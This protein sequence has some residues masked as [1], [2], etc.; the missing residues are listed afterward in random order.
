MKKRFAALVLGLALL[1]NLGCPAWA[2]EE[3]EKENAAALLYSMELFQGIGTDAFGNPIFALDKA[4]TRA[5]SVT[6]LVR[7]LGGEGEVLAGDWTMPF[8][9]VP[10]WAAGYVAYAY[11]KG[12]TQG[13][14]PT[15]FDP[16][17]P[18][19]AAEYLSFVLRALGYSSEKDFQW[20]SAWTLTDKLGLTKKEYDETTSD[21][22]RGDMAW[23]SFRALEQKPKGQSKALWQVLE[24]EDVSQVCWWQ[25]NVETCQPGRFVLSFAPV[26]FL[27]KK[28]AY[29]KF[30]VTKASINGVACR[31][32][33]QYS[34]AKAVKDHI[35][36]REEALGSLDLGEAFALVYLKYDEAAAKA[37]ASR[38]E[39]LN[40]VAY[41][42]LTFCLELT[43]TRKDGTQVEE[44]VYFDYYLNGYGGRL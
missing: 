13:R 28:T 25:E 30:E 27:G 14:S 32:E 22:T 15:R 24:L 9:D 21:F 6:M 34:T 31:V 33:E 42:V 23:V 8:Q 12:L 18:V 26:E 39:T 41:P 2:V 16:D 5:Q 38:D 20:D 35:K 37:A 40:G 7:L 19:G 36:E 44:V 11:E 4:P 29:T 10:E 43:G 1:G 17:S 3:H